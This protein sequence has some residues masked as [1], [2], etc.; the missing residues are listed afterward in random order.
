M[1]K[2]EN[3]A[4]VKRCAFMRKCREL[5]LSSNTEA[6]IT[7]CM[8]GKPD[9]G[10][11][12]LAEKLLAIIT[13]CETE[14]EMIDKAS[15]LQ[16][17]L[18]RKAE[19]L[20]DLLTELPPDFIKIEEELKT[21]LYSSEEITLAFARF[22]G[23]CVCEYSN[24]IEYK[25]RKPLDSELRSTYAY[26]ICE[27]LLKYGLD[28]CFRCD[29]MPFPNVMEAVYYIDKPYVA[30]DIMKLL[31]K[32]GGNPYIW[33]ENEMFYDMVNSDVDYDVLDRNFNTESP[34]FYNAICRFHCW[35]VL[36]GFVAEDGTKEKDY[37][38]HEKYSIKP[39]GNRGDW[40]VI[41]N[42]KV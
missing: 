29:E 33:V 41:E 24:F 35:L 28:P 25:L 14:Q 4:S 2:A 30:A 10:K 40:V 11:E 3:P 38:N 37:I 26:D 22:C 15:I 42:K 34:Y 19:K 13:E 31:I 5:K 39:I 36:C 16:S 32:N 20:C 8:Y 17:E 1:L 23:T 7:V 18:S 9:E 12:E 6:K 21:N 27:L